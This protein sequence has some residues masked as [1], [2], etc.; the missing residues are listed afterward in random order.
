MGN[1]LVTTTLTNVR[2]R[3]LFCARTSGGRGDGE[4]MFNK[5][6]QVGLVVGS[7]MV[8]QPVGD[9]LNVAT[10]EE[11]ASYVRRVVAWEQLKR[12]MTDLRNQ[13]YLRVDRYS[14]HISYVVEE[15]VAELPFTPDFAYGF[16]VGVRLA[17]PGP[18]T[19]LQ[20][21]TMRTEYMSRYWPGEERVLWGAIKSLVKE[22]QPFV[23][24]TSLTS[25][26]DQWFFDWSLPAVVVETNAADATS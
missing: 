2:S 6:R 1:E 17:Q 3:V 8:P 4:N 5:E 22:K 15:K 14:P 11:N 10:F 23:R 9:S 13:R 19:R 12:V 20:V 18:S 25:D 21:S 26:V 7:L 24:T 16:C